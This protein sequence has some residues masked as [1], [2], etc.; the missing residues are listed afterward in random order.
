MIRPILSHRLEL[1]EVLLASGVSIDYIET[2]LSIYNDYNLILAYIKN[3]GLILIKSI[4]NNYWFKSFE[5]SKDPDYIYNNYDHEEFK[6]VLSTISEEYLKNYKDFLKY[7]VKKDYDYINKVAEELTEA[8]IDN[9]TDSLKENTNNNIYS[10]SENYV[11][12]S[13]KELLSN[14]L[15]TFDKYLIK[16]IAEYTLNTKEAKTKK[17]EI[18]NL[19]EGLIKKVINLSSYVSEEGRPI[20]KK[21]EFQ[22]IINKV[23]NETLSNES[24]KN[25]FQNNYGLYEE[26]NNNPVLIARC[27]ILNCVKILDPLG[28]KEPVYN[29]TLDNF[30]TKRNEEFLYL[31]SE[32]L[33]EELTKTKVFFN[34]NDI[35]KFINTYIIEGCISEE[36]P[37]IEKIY[38]EGYF[39]INNKVVENSNIKNLK[40]TSL[41]VYE[42][43][44]LLNE[45]I[46]KRSHEGKLNDTT[47]YRFMLY[48]PFSYCLK[49]IGFKDAIYSLILM[50]KSEA[51]KTGAF[52]IGN[53]FYSNLEEENTASSLSA[54][55]GIIEEN[56]FP[57]F[58]DEAY[59]LI[60]LNLLA[61][62]DFMKKNIDHTITR[63]LKDVTNFNK[64]KSYQAL[65]LAVYAM[66]E[67][68]LKFKDFIQRRYKIIDYTKESVISKEEA[69]EF[70]K[71]Y[72]PFSKDSI[73]NKLN[74]IGAEYKKKFIQLLENK[75]PV[76]FD[77]E[78]VTI[79]ILKEIAEETSE[80]TNKPIDFIEEMYIIKDSTEKYNYDV[81]EH[82]RT[83]LN[84]EFKK[85]NPLGFNKSYEG[86]S[87]VKAVTKSDF[88]F[89]TWNKYRTQATEEKEYI[90]NVSKFVSYVNNRIEEI[91]EIETILEALG[92]TDI[93]TEKAT[94][95]NKSL[96]DFLKTQ[97][98]IKVNDKGTI[99]NIT[100]FY[101][102][103]PEMANN[104]FSINI[105]LTENINY[106]EAVEV[107]KDPEVLETYDNLER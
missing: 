24:Y 71:L 49:Q 70:N 96:N 19:A 107:V 84:S 88:N 51:N 58:V 69:E 21:Y 81:K 57:K 104:L 99:K 64:N 78:E 46:S 35:E 97:H 89:I 94:K 32:E 68:D 41:D 73:L 33:V 83:I 26:K 62:F 86:F 92:L 20:L 42:A 23:I 59:S 43:I 93:L 34:K 54:L 22:S 87:F 53:K 85:Y 82:I 1:K 100:G 52:T 95:E 13:M 39:I 67:T 103:T 80:A 38:K 9:L 47:V 31:T 72:M 45:I 4:N 106:A 65:A 11:N 77:P 25:Y 102:N 29:L 2:E 8:I 36:I 101:L 3:K 79:N 12:K 105:D 56:T 6:E 61:M 55:G 28:V 98:K 66:N 14:P 76:L 75:D 91:V 37:I 5:T 16:N 50:G 30:T 40:Y 7:K 17:E 15:E 60:K 74:V 48:A 27:N 63:V 10:K 90:I 44:T 18:N